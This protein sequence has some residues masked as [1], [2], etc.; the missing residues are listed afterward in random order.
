MDLFADLRAHGLQWRGAWQPTA[1]DALPALPN[2]QAV[3]LVGMVGIVGSTFW[4]QFRGTTFFSDGLPDPLDRWSRSIASTLAQRYGGYALF[5]FEGPPYH[6][7]QRWADRAE[8]TQSSPLML[9]I[10]PDFGL[11]HAYRFALALPQQATG[12]WCQAPSANA[13]LPSEH[14]SS[15]CTS[16]SQQPCL[17]TC[18]VDA[19]DGENYQHTR[20]AAHLQTPQGQACMQTG[21]LARRACPIGQAFQYQSEHAAFHMQAFVRWS[22]NQLRA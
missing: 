16:C 8:P 19:F 13:P 18:P 10:H 4:P 12:A 21:C 15:L 9:R 14:R 20:C 5:P 1:A 7:F 3:A 17:R 6:P 2:Q 11:W 22:K